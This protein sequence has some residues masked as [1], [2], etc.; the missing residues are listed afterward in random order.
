MIWWPAAS[1][2]ST[3]SVGQA[4]VPAWV[5]SP[6]Y[7]IA[8]ALDV[9]RS[10]YYERVARLLNE[11]PIDRQLVSELTTRFGLEESW[12]TFTRRYPE[13]G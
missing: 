2:R 10:K 13:H 11:A 12:A 5:L 9:H 8:I 1:S 7:L 4:A 3:R 6:E